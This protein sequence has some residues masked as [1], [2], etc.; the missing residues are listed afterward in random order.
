MGDMDRINELYTHMAVRYGRSRFGKHQE[1]VYREI[2][3]FMADCATVDEATAKLRNSEYYLEP[4]RAVTEDMLEAFIAFADEENM[5]DLKAVY[6]S[7]MAEIKNDLNAIYDASYQEKAKYEKSLYYTTMEA[8]ANTFVSW[9]SLLMTDIT[10][11]DEINTYVNEIRGYVSLLKKPSS[12]ITVLAQI[13]SFRELIPAEDSVIDMFAKSVDVIMRT[14]NVPVG[15]SAVSDEAVD[16]EWQKICSASAAVEDA[17]RYYLSG[18][19]ESYA[20][21]YAPD[22]ADGRYTFREGEVK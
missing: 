18:I 12:D 17:G 15:N 1:K 9:T 5:D 4:S 8:F 2:I 3:D 20:T 11:A 7:K 22:S 10:A 13:P 14:G 6:E 16:A 21:A 19:R